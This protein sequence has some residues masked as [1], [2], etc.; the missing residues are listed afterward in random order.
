MVGLSG[1]QTTI[2]YG[3]SC[4]SLSVGVLCWVC[5]VQMLICRSKGQVS[6]CSARIMTHLSA[7]NLLY[8]HLWT[9][10]SARERNENGRP[11]RRNM[12]VT[13]S[14]FDSAVL[15]TSSPKRIKSKRSKRSSWTLTQSELNHGTA[16]ISCHLIRVISV[17]PR[18][19]RTITVPQ[20]G[21]QYLLGSFTGPSLGEWRTTL[22]HDFSCCHAL[23]KYSLNCCYSSILSCFAYE[24]EWQALMIFDV[25]WEI[26]VAKGWSAYHIIQN[27][28]RCHSWCCRGCCGADC[29]PWLSEWNPWMNASGFWCLD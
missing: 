1:G 26:C 3:T 19:R 23:Q 24:E 17:T 27:C 21:H 25:G 2:R 10:L 28:V 18:A 4:S 14:L 9:R 22:S 29:C 11:S 13:P 20:D 6:S 7:E 12:S 8:K 16:V 15:L 5:S